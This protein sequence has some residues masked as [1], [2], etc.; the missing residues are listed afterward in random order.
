MEIKKI[1]K[2]LI[3]VALF[4]LV[5]GNSQLDTLLFGEARIKKEILAA[6]T[7]PIPTKRTVRWENS[8]SY[9]DSLFQLRGKEPFR[10]WSFEDK[11]DLPRTLLAHLL[12]SNEIPEV[13]RMMM[14]MKP[15]GRYGSKWLLNPKG[16]YDFSAT[17]LT[18]ILYL[19]DN[20]PEILYPETKN[21]LVKVLL[22]DQGEGFSDAVPHTLGRIKDSENHV[23]MSQGS[24]YLKNRYIMMHGNHE[25]KFNNEQN[26]MENGILD[27]L[28]ELSEMGL[29]EFNSIPYLGYT[30]AALL[31]LEAFGSENVKKASRDVLDYLCFSYAIGSYHYQYFPPFRRR[32]EKAKSEALSKDYQTV[33]MKTWMSFHPTIKFTPHMDSGES[34]ALI[35]ACMPYRPA[36]EVISLIFNKTPG[37]FARLGHGSGSSPELYSAGP[38]YLLSAGGVNRGKWSVIVARPITLF[39]NDNA[40]VLADL[41][42]VAGTGND[43]M[44][45]NN[46]GVYANFACAAGLVAVPEGFKPLSENEQ[47]KI[48]GSGDSLLIAV[49]SSAEIGILAIF[50]KQNPQELAKKL[51]EANPVPEKLKSQF[52]F[53]AGSKIDFDVK[54]P[55]NKWVIKAVDGKSLDRDFDCWPL[56]SGAWNQKNTNDHY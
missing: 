56:I 55:K 42:H 52:Q 2:I 49:H 32:Y 14:S 53:P 45:W 15:W 47:W 25:A 24:K 36:D 48:F 16:G 51:I 31:N 43:F 13:N 46:T 54:A 22:N 7:L 4:M 38:G 9:A 35:A 5:F 10:N 30:L 3:P 40:T 41:F 34:H 20:K 44:K 27:K 29:Y 8:S 23:L 50:E 33:F 26:G 28:K 6:S 12:A 18:T 1:M 21:H 17:A 11:M 37:Y 39:L 19:F